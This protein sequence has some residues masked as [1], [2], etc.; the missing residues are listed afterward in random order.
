MQKI[1][2]GLKVNNEI[3]I[4]EIYDQHTKQQIEKILLQNRISYFIKWPK[5]KLLSRRKPLC[6][7]CINENSYDETEAA[8]RSLGEDVLDGVHFI[9]RKSGNSFL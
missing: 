5:A 8:I 7:L 1:Y 3:E 4:C 2:T 9:L 6:I